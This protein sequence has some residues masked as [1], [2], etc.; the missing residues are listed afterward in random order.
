MW[1]LVRYIHF[2]LQTFKIIFT[3]LRFTFQILDGSDCGL[4]DTNTYRLWL[5]AVIILEL[6]E[7]RGWNS[8]PQRRENYFHLNIKISLSKKTVALAVCSTDRKPLIWT[9]TDCS[10]TTLSLLHSFI[11]YQRH[12]YW[13][14]GINNIQIVVVILSWTNFGF[15]SC[16]LIE[17]FCSD[18][19]LRQRWETFWEPKICMR[20]SVTE[21]A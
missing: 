13:W 17:M 10:S 4:A 18:S 5:I 3:I 20:S 12:D 1:H 16:F 7:E 9:I 6:D 19:W 11:H 2:L 14:M 15:L 21:R 8:D